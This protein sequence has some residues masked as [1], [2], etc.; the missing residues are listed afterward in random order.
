MPIREESETAMVTDSFS[1]IS[2]SDRETPMRVDSVSLMTQ[3]VE[4]SPDP[5]LTEGTEQ[6]DEGMETTTEVV[7][8]TLQVAVG[9][10]GTP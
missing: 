6:E 10:R 9:S 5:A 7:G 8:A 1:S 2:V 4:L 3:Y